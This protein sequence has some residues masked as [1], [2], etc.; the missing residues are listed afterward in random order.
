MKRCLLASVL[1]VA[2]GLLPSA[3]P[4]QEGAGANWDTFNGTLD[5]RRY[6]TLDQ[7]NTTNVRKIHV[8][9]A[10]QTSVVNPQTSFENTP[11]V[12]DGIM[13]LATGT[14]V[15][16]AMD[17]AT[18]A[19]S[20]TYDPK[21][22][23]G[24]GFLVQLKLC[25]G[26]NNRGVAYYKGR[27]YIGTIDGRLIALDAT[28]GLPVPTFGDPGTPGQAKVLDVSK[29]YSMTA[30][31]IIWDDK[32]F[33]GAA[34]SEFQTRGTFNAYDV[35]T[36]KRL[37]QW[38]TIPAPGE[39][40]GDTW[41]AK[42]PDS[43]WPWSKDKKPYEVGGAGVW[44]N[45]TIDVANHQ[46]IFGTGNPNPDFNGRKRAGDNL[47]SCSVVSLDSDT[48]K[49]RW[50]FQEVRHDL[51]DYDQAAAPILFTTTITGQ[52][53]EA[54]G[55]AGKTGW[56]Y[57]LDR[58]TGKSLI[59]M[60]DID[61]PQDPSLA[62]A[63][64]QRV[65]ATV[66]AFADQNNMWTPSKVTGVHLAPGISGGSEWSPISFNPKFNYAY[67][68]VIN[69]PMLFCLLPYDIWQWLEKIPP[70]AKECHDQAVLSGIA[71][72]ISPLD[73]GGMAVVAS[74]DPQP[75]GSFV[76]IDVNTDTVK[77]TYKTIPHPV[78]GTLA[79]AGGL[80]FAGTSD[81]FFNALDAETGKLLWRFQTGAAID[82]APMTYSVDGRQYVAIASGGNAVSSLP[83]KRPTDPQ[84]KEWTYFRQGGTVF[85][86]A[87]DKE[88]E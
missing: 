80:V 47:Y 23:V 59:E 87:L 27:I 5:S 49:L 17:A 7:I 35:N 68:S 53:V 11:I 16:Y 42:D 74:T 79:T 20:W 75:T 55:A 73:V 24:P 29:G 44:M 82:A 41:P 77:W 12:V 52:P 10:F 43:W 76:A 86:F 45:P 58:K 19:L 33:F 56:F 85:V 66:A 37:W 28:S 81:G 65:P 40:G 46:V 31:P 64:Q 84:S 8:T 54:V 3:A 67:V 26:Q 13:Y 62:T 71:S 6:S 25:C 63:K 61:V 21:V 51:W 48:G 2:V 88:G 30:A 14:D 4:A 15:V 32:I 34:G 39:P 18:G 57:I 78:S 69:K 9:W 83:N 60:K 38:Y 50:Y 72:L 36:G 22:K 70:G 1:F